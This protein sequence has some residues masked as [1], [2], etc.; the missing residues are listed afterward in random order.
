MTFTPDPARVRTYPSARRPYVEVRDGDR[1][2][3]AIVSAWQDEMVLVEYPPRVA[4][5]T[6][7][8]EP[9]RSWV[10]KASAVRIRRADAIW[11]HTD[12]DM[13]WHADQDKLINY[14]ADPWTVY[15]QELPG[16]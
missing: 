1:R 9:E 7:E 6:Y 11:A 12:D 15:S 4:S 16:E 13:G 10:H 8:G 3:H 14:R 5:G 2:F